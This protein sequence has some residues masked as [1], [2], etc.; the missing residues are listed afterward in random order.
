[1]V[2]GVELDPTTATVFLTAITATNAVIAFLLWRAMPGLRGLGLV[3]LAHLVQVVGF[4]FMGAKA[5]HLITL[6]NIAHVSAIALVTEGL[7]MFVGK[8]L[9]V[10]LLVVTP[11]VTA[12]LW[13]T[14]QVYHPS[15]VGLRVAAF[16]VLALLL[17]GRCLG[18]ALRHGRRFG[19]ANTVLITGLVLHMV[20]SSGRGILA[21][22][23]PDPD[24]ISRPDVHSWLMLELVFIIN[25]IF[26]SVLVMVGGLISEELRL[27]TQTLSDAQRL[28]DRLREFLH[29]LSHELR[30]PL[31]IIDRTA[32]MAQLVQADAGGDL[33][34]RLEVIRSTAGRMGGLVNNLLAAERADM[35]E[36]RDE[37]VDLGALLQ[38]ITA[39]LTHKHEQ[40]AIGLTL[41]PEPIM[42]TGDADMLSVAFTNVIDNALKFSPPCQ[43]IQVG[44]RVEAGQA[45][46]SVSDRGIGF[47]PDQLS[48]IGERFFRAGNAVKISGSGLGTHLTRNIVAKHGG[49]VHF[50]N[51]RDG[52]AQVDIVLPLRPSP[53]EAD[54]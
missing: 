16:S 40:R 43:S 53:L 48:R 25:F 5:P 24:Y 22:T 9:R 37:L 32:E 21:L 28:N 45:M 10:W 23:H 11:L 36:T 13:E 14:M 54:D 1:M 50:R 27:R 29:L 30:T 6:Q 3:A 2:T 33:S 39:M 38:E 52:G 35:D 31:A 17:Y 19:V 51:R 44:L 8:P 46:V 4:L 7:V 20:W 18:V 42:V 34:E 26:F 41:P 47:P 12:V 15:W 49:S